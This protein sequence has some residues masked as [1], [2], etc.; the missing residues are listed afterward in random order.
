MKVSVVP[1]MTSYLILNNHGVPVRKQKFETNEQVE[2]LEFSEAR[3]RLQGL[4]QAKVVRRLQASIVRIEE[5]GTLVP[6]YF[7]PR[8][9]AALAPRVFRGV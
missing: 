6:V 3:H 9:D 5:T 1:G 4:V 2:L 7:E 8:P